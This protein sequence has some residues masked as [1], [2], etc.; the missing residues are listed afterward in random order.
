LMTPPDK[1][2]EP[3]PLRAVFTMLPPESK[4][5]IDLETNWAM[6][7]D[8]AIQSGG[9]VFTPEDAGELRK[10]LVRQSVPQVEHH[11][12]RLWQWWGL[13]AVVVVLLTL[14]WVGRKIAGL[15]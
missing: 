12:Q 14:E 15:P 6:L 2:K 8:L 13:L 9:K 1:G 10:L 3:G 11:E 4:E 5:M 7:D